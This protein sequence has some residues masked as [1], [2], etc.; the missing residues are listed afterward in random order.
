MNRAESC[1]V[2]LLQ[3]SIEAKRSYG[4]L[5]SAT[6]IFGDTDNL[7]YHYS[8]NPYKEL[9]LNAYKEAGVD[10]AQVAYVEGE[11]LGIKVYLSNFY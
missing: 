7:F 4:T 3:K 9:L 11:G 2:I 1:V 5:L 10:P 8:Y 6:G